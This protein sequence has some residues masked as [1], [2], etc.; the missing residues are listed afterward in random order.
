MKLERKMHFSK[1]GKRYHLRDQKI[2]PKADT[3][4]WNNSV[5]AHVTA[6]GFSQTQFMQP[7]PTMYSHAPQKSEK[8]AMAPEPQYFDHHPGRFFYLKNHDTQSIFSAPSMP[9]NM[10][11][12]VYDFEP[13]LSDVRWTAEK[14]GMEVV[15][16]FALPYG[17]DV[18]E[19]WKVTV[20][21]KKD[22]PQ[23][24]SLY[25]YFPVGF[26]SWMNT[27]G[28]Y[29]D[30]L[31]GMLAY[32]LTPYRKLKDYDKVKQMKDY[33]YFIAHV[34]PVTWEAN[35]AKFEGYGGLRNPDGIRH[36]GL[37]C[38]EAS[39]ETT[40]CAM[41]HVLELS[42][43]ESKTIYFIFGPANNRDEVLTMKNKYLYPNA[44]NDAV[45]QFN[46]LYEE[47]KGCIQ[48]QTPDETVNNFINHWIIKQIVYH[49]KTLRMV[50]DP[51]TRNHI[52]DTMAMTYLDPGHVKDLYKLALSQ[53]SINGEMPDGIL[54]TE[55]AELKYVNQ[56]PHRDH[57]VWAAFAIGAYLDETN[58]V[59]FLDEKVPYA[60]D[61][62]P[63]T[64]Y[65]HVCKGIEWLILDRSER[66]L[67]YIGQG[68]WNDPMNMVGYKG[69]GESVWLS[70]ATVYA[71]KVWLP[72]CQFF[73]DHKRVRTF[74][75]IV[76]SMN[77][78][79]NHV[80][81]DGC[82]YARGFNDDGE[83]F[84][85]STDDEGQIFLNTQSF[86][87]L[88]G[89]ASGERLDLLVNAVEER[90][91]TPYGVTLLA[92]SYT[93]MHEK[94]GRVTQKHPSTAE[95]GSIYC[96]ANAFYTYALYEK[97]Y[98]QKAYDIL[99][100]LIPG[101][102]EH[103]MKQRE[104]LPLYIPNYYRGA[105]NERVIGKSSHLMNTGSLPWIYRC[106]VEGLFGLKGKK[107]GL[108]IEPQLPKAFKDVSLTRVFRGKTLNIDMHQKEGMKVTEI[109]LNGNKV[110]GNMVT[111]EAMKV[112]NDIIVNCPLTK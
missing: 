86:G 79:L 55:D 2:M 97:G 29:D 31:G 60:D 44:I 80:A 46:N 56:V 69:R 96:H 67:S 61:E 92:P 17:D 1:D 52:Q 24:V 13:G 36:E 105:H 20:R 78:T 91:T 33:V 3:F 76:Q 23:K 73:K 38:T 37:S 41:E 53:Q 88:C 5:L 71:M 26:P 65:K 90:L 107:N 68:D 75:S 34:K 15:I 94:I 103:D 7:E 40:I 82:W 9:M 43:Y 98:G 8:A 35:S 14:D 83:A 112:N 59:G 70:Q 66:G 48:I 87:I 109:I 18:V 16:Q 51:Q 39:Y 22:E 28:H 100:T 21:N 99:R 42:P 84:G 25:P 50:T 108:K 101:P 27:E 74:E 10:E 72:I 111:M 11:L 81:W 89:A 62:T 19:L 64:V 32:A 110:A 58:D 4:L 6:M 102:D 63:E 30:E 93:Y 54:L 45:E 85:V 95:N 47:N 49:A 104:H 77:D 12:D 106:F 57:C